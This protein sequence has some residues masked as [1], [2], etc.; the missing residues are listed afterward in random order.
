MIISIVN[1][2]T[3][4]DSKVQNVI[5]V[6]NRQIA[7]DFEPHWFMGAHLRL[8]GKVGGQPTPQLPAE[9]RGDA[10]VYLWDQID[11]SGVLG[12]HAEN[13]QGIPFGFVLTEPARLEF[14]STRGALTQ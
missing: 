6:I 8:E 5:R 9:L 14:V 4:P 12:Y 7:Q 2:S 3:V 10:I 13:N 11:V 1:F